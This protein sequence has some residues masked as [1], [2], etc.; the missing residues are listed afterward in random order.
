MI[1]LIKLLFKWYDARRRN[2]DLAILW[3]ICKERAA[4][5]DQA[6]A[7]FAVHAFNDPAWMSLGHDA[8]FAAINKLK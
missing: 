3:P 4:S 1:W 8:V 6:K 7:V 2:I 5:L